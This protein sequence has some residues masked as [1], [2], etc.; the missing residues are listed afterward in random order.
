MNVL[1]FGST[2]GTACALHYFTAMVRM[3]LAVMPYNPRYFEA[4]SPFERIQIR[5]RHGPTP[6]KI[7]EVSEELVGLCRRNRFDAV[8]VLAEN[9]ID[10][11][12]IETI[13][14]TVPHPPLFLYHSHDNN[15]SPGICKG[16]DFFEALALFDF[17]FTTK[18]QN[19]EKYKA[20]GQRNS[21]FIPSAYEPTVHRPVPETE[22]RLGDRLFDVIFIGTYD[23]SRDPQL[24]AIGWD[25]L[26]VW[27]S[28]W[29]RYQ[30][31]SQYRDRI[32]PTPIYYLEFADVMSHC[33]I[34]LGLLREEVEDRHT[35]RTFE[36]P[37]CGALQL[38]PRN[39]EILSF[40]EE[41]KEIACFSSLE[42]LREKADYYLS[43]DGER[44]KIAQG[45]YQKCLG[46]KHT[47]V[48]RVTE[49]FRLAQRTS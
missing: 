12:T 5:L 21:Y 41:G 22:S 39:D 10:V 2:D 1:F 43:H 25:R 23:Y 34:S 42:E 6:K 45:G 27:G 24:E 46:G 35:Q 48:D 32:V 11:S 3:G 30:N 14:K 16:K 38:A 4:E 37:A 7:M 13:R 33:K 29:T 49:M 31:F 40:F 17:V 18:S 44:Q 36:I 15:F 47:Y 19:V 20:L 8:F 28:H 9:F 26:R